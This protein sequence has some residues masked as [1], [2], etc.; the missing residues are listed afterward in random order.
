M[1]PRRIIRAVSWFPVLTIIFAVFGY[2]KTNSATP[3]GETHNAT[4]PMFSS[5]FF[6][7]SLT[8]VAVAAFQTWVNYSRDWYDPE[9]ALKYQGVF[10]GDTLC[11]ARSAAA[12]QYKETR[13]YDGQTKEVEIVLDVFEDI[14]FY[15]M[16]DQISPEVA[17]HHFY[18]WIRGYIQTASDYIENYRR[19]D[20]AAYE[21][22]KYLLEQTAKV[23]ARKMKVH[24]ST[25]S[26]GEEDI[27][28]F[29]DE[30]AAMAD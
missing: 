1:S 18:H 19:D 5:P 26:L 2:L 29:V 13:K 14:G 17:H 6:W 23:E 4:S 11:K 21:H 25:L 28:E 9:L 24:L 22:C 30:A 12:K 15:V 8:A 16:H 3:A 10:E 7:L 27:A 20:P